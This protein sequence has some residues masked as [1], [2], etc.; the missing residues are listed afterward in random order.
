MRK[1]GANSVVIED[2]PPEMTV[3]GIPGRLVKE[4]R[5]RSGPN[6]RID[7]EHHLIPD[8]VGEVMSL[9]IDRLEFLEARAG[10][11]KNRSVASRIDDEKSRIPQ[12]KETAS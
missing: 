2:V 6:G 10:L 1:V 8:P 4:V 7:L 3:V 12:L 9:L 11:F 5:R